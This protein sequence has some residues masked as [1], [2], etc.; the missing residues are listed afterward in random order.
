MLTEEDKAL[1]VSIGASSDFLESLNPPE[2]LLPE[3]LDAW[4]LYWLV[5]S[6]PIYRPDG[7][8]VGFSIP[9]LLGL[10]EVYDVEDRRGCVEKVQLIWD[11]MRKAAP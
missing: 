4:R 3:N 10:M 11:E 6:Q 1:L 9:A 8:L 2:P 5:Q 7:Q